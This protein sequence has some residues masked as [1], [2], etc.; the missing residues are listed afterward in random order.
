MGPTL[1]GLEGRMN[2]EMVEGRRGE[3]S[4]REERTE[5]KDQMARG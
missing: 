3:R 2:S 5:R 4:R 1:W